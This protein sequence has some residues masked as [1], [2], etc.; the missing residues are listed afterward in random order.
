M[1]VVERSEIVIQ[2][3]GLQLYRSKKWEEEPRSN[4]DRGDQETERKSRHAAN[5]NDGIDSVNLRNSLL[6]YLSTGVVSTVVSSHTF[7]TGLFILHFS[8][9]AF[10]AAASLSPSLPPIPHPVFDDSRP[11]SGI[12]TVRHNL[13]RRALCAHHSIFPA[14]H[15]SQDTSG[16][17]DRAGTLL[18][19]V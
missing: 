18:T 17:E 13:L 7:E 4:D 9:V 2:Q 6:D 11:D 15:R 19:N 16:V 12:R 3:G 5:G 14:C 10:Y 8:L 1:P